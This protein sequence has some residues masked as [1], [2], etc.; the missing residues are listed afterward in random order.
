M[1]AAHEAM[2]LTVE[3]GGATLYADTLQPVLAQD[4]FAVAVG[5]GAIL[6]AEQV[7]DAVL[8]STAR[9]VA[10][11]FATSLVGTWMPPS[12]TLVYIDPVV[13]RADRMEALRLGVEHNQRA[14]YDLGR[15]KVIWL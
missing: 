4:G 11:E 14:I 12:G 2:A 13:I 7:T 9:A 10:G 5:Q 6:P 3:N 15:K 1:S 8:A